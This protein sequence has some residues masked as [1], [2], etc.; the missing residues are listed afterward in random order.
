MFTILIML[1]LP[2]MI[3][4]QGVGGEIRRPVRT[5][6]NSNTRPSRPSNNTPPAT[7][8][9]NNQQSTNRVQSAILQKLINNMVYVEGGSFIMGTN[10]IQ[11]GSSDEYP[12]HKVALSSFSI[13]KYEVTQEE[14]GE[15]MGSNPSKFMGSKK[16]VEQVTWRECQ[17]FIRKL[18]E[19]TGRT[20]RL[21]TEAEWEYA[22]R[23]GSHSSNNKYSGSNALGLVAWY[24]DNSNGTT[25]D[26]GTNN[27]N[28][29]GLYDMNGNVWEW[30]QDYY[31][32]NYY[33]ESSY[34][35]PQGPTNGNSYVYR[36]GGYKSIANY[37]NMSIRNS[38]SAVN[39]FEDV[40]LRLVL[41][42][43]NQAG[44]VDNSIHTNSSPT[45]STQVQN[46]NVD[47]SV[48]VYYNPSVLLN[49]SK[50]LKLNSVSNN[51]NETVLTLSC[52]NNSASV[53]MSI[54]RSA[55]LY[56]DGIKYT[57]IFAEGIAYSPDKTYFSEKSK[58]FKL[59]FKALPLNTTSFDFIEN[60]DSDWKM[61]GIRLMN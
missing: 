25:H 11:K 47:S 57:M 12:A 32:R 50:S 1:T 30:C 41:D 14:W 48:K 53:G 35:N 56:A 60:D 51:N 37:C 61:Y 59:H 19:L 4:A 2:L 54:D 38:S 7:N 46:N 6:S 44:G 16:P 36:G 27:P 55:Y 43:N 26:V 18:N 40:G 20:F 39:R 31:D 28:E 5:N 58:T 33:S 23:G 21:P 10:S 22:A 13:G 29:L 3:M 49:K 45:V 9:A 52:Y 8:S 42:H 15:V 17:V 34:K 24:S